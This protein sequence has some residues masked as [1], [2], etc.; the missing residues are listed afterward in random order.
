MDFYTRN[1]I[2]TTALNETLSKIQ[3][4]ELAKKRLTYLRWKATENLDKLLFEFETNVKKVDANILWAP[5]SEI[6]IEHLNKHL[7]AANNV[8][9]MKHNAVQKL[10]SNGQIKI[11]ATVSDKPTDAIVIGAKFLIANTGNF[12]C[13]LNST[14]EYDALLEAKKIIVIG[15]IDSFLSS[16]TD[17]PLAKQLYA[18]YETGKLSYPAEILSRPGKPRGLNAEI[19][20]ILIDDGRSKLIENPINRPLYSLLNFDLPPVC[21]MQQLSVQENE[22]TQTDSLNYFLYPFVSDLNTFGFHFRNNYGYRLINQYVPYMI[23]M[24]DHVMEARTATQKLDKMI[25]LTGLLDLDKSGTVLNPKR[26]KDKQRFEKYAE[27]HFFGKH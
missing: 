4:I 12:F 19:V 20:L 23:D 17:L 15:G 2:Y 27:H 18:I 3:D 25:P 1:K 8:R 16:Q 26:F 7:Q 22:W 6:A 10:V 9:F 5:N 11:P 14:D 24:S 13:A 21:P